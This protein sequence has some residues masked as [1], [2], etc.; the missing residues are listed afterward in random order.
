MIEVMV[1][2]RNWKHFSRL[3]R[4]TREVLDVCD[5]VGIEPVLSASLAVFAYTQNSAME[6]HDV[7]LSCSE[8]Q[9][10]RLRRALRARGIDSRITTWHVLQARKS[11]LKVDF[12]AT[13]YWMRDI[14]E[15][16]ELAKIGDMRFRMVSIDVLRELYRRGLTDTATKVDDDNPNKHRGIREKLRSPGFA[17]RLLTIVER[18]RGSHSHT[19]DCSGGQ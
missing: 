14:V 11:D 13:E 16:N 2:P 6:V 5:D 1:T 4:F 9:F 19:R 15:R 8:S 7:D 18:G 3:M 17:R 12:D 10:P